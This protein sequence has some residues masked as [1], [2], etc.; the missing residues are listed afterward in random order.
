MEKGEYETR[1]RRGWGNLAENLTLRRLRA[2][3]D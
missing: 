1:R 3:L 2:D